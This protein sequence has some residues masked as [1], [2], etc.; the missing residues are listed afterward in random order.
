MDLIKIAEEIASKL[1]CDKFGSCIHFAE[2]LV[3]RLRKEI[4]SGE[5][6]FIVIEGYVNTPADPPQMQ[7]TWIVYNNKKIDPTFK[8]FE[9]M[10]PKSTISYSP[11][12]KAYSAKQYL[13]LVDSSSFFKERRKLFLKSS[14]REK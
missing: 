11:A 9:K 10:F 8:Q 6:N 7:H 4:T 14:K 3:E 12:K 1:H 2:M 5:I 13:K